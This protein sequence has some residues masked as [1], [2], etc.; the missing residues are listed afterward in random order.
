M[1]GF[2][3]GFISGSLRYGQFFL[4]AT[5]EAARFQFCAIRAGG[6][7][8]QT[9]IN[10]DTVLA[11]GWFELHIN[12]NIEVPAATGIFVE[13]TR[14]ESILTQTVAIPHFKIVAV[15]VDLTIFPLCRTCIDGYPA[16]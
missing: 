15:V 11:F 14:A 9:Q 3:L 12:H 7:V 1:K 6:S 16:Q 2:D 4:K 5:I 8:G 13:A 10:T